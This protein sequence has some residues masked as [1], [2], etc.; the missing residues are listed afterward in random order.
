MVDAHRIIV[1][2]DIHNCHVDWYGISNEERMERFV[3]HMREEY[4]KEPYEYILLLGDYSLDFWAWGI[5]GC[6]VNHQESRTQ[7]F[8]EKVVSRLPAPCKMIAGN[9]E[10]YGEAK[11]REITGCSRQDAVRIGDVL[12]ILMDS[13]G[14]NLAPQEHSDGTYTPIDVAFVQAQMARFPDCRVVLC[15]HHF[16]FD[17]EGEE[18]K[19]LVRDPR[20]VCLFSGHVHLSS[21]LQLPEE[22]GGKHLIRTGNYSYSSAPDPISDGWGFREVI[23]DRNRLVSRYIM[24][25]NSLFLDG[26]EM[27]IPYRKQGEICLD[28]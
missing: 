13:Y 24:P 17:R 4:E 11:W 9:H 5:Q 16:D 6:Y 14:A 25:E 3:R 19:A 2:S 18:A 27:Q 22:L 15:S 21:V 26:K 10:Q 8:V 28:L 1:T 7:E 23:F 12:F 20:I